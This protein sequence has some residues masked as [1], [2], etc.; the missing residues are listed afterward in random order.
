MTGLTTTLSS[1]QKQLRMATG[2]FPPC[3]LAYNGFTS[4]FP[5]QTVASEFQ[6]SRRKKRW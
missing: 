4:Y 3:S 5:T 2:D 1:G 6:L